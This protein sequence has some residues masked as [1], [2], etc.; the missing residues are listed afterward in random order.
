MRVTVPA[1]TFRVRVEAKINILLKAAEWLVGLAFSGA[2]YAYVRSQSAWGLSPELTVMVSMFVGASASWLI[3]VRPAK[4]L[5][6]RFPF[7]M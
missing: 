2:A 1:D 6:R 3:V 4:Q 5:E 7:D